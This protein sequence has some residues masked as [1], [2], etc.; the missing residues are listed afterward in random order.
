MPPHSTGN[1]DR[2]AVIRLSALGDL[3]L[4]TGV[5]DFWR[6]TR[7]LSFCCITRSHLAPVLS[8]HPAVE[9]CEALPAEDIQGR[10]AST[11]RRLASRYSGW[12]LID[13]HGTLRSRI[14]AACW[15]GPVR[16]YPKA[17]LARRLYQRTGMG[18]LRHMLEARNVPQRYALAL[19][20]KAPPAEELR[21]MIRLRPEELA[22]GSSLLAGTG[23]APGFVA[24][25]PYATHPDK[26]WPRGHWL[27]L[28]DLLRHAG[29]PFAVIG[30]DPRPLYP[31][32]AA[33]LT[34]ATE[35]RTTCAVLSMASALVSSD[36]GPMHL[37]TAVGT[38]VTAL[39]GPTTK[40]WGFFPSG[41]RD[42]VLEQ[43]YPCRPCSLHGTSSCTQGRKCLASIGP[44]QVLEAVQGLFDR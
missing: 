36:S 5:L 30:R 19:E 41:P 13:L 14:L 35:L 7:G 4:T 17:G 15:K 9:N 31:G 6:R 44:S 28:A 24:L 10:W 20:D 40:A 3:V 21:P 32:L 1:P 25:H 27:A 33:D 2:W 18:F 11:A 8:N 34:N 42:V 16:R 39:F 43:D 38:P 37:A 23:L 22:E 12:G 26:A 29:I